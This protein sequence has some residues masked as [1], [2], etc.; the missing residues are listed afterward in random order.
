VRQQ[1]FAVAIPTEAPT[2]RALELSGAGADLVLA[3]SV[4]EAV[5][6]LREAPGEKPAA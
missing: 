6:V 1:R 3:P 4:D 2:H 5:A